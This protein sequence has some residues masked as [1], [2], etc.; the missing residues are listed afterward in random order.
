MI[1]PLLDDQKIAHVYPWKCTE[2]ICSDANF[3]TEQFF[4]FE[5]ED[6]EIEG[7]NNNDIIIDKPKGIILLNNYI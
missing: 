4:T 3:I 7:N 6:K 5:Y 1:E 2:I